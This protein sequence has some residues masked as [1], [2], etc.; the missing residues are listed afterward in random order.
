MLIAF[1]RVLAE[2]TRVLKIVD[3]LVTV[4]PELKGVL[5]L[6]NTFKNPTKLLNKEAMKLLRNLA[7]EQIKTMETY[8]NKL[9]KISTFGDSF[10]K[11]LDEAVGFDTSK[12]INIEDVKISLSSSWL[13]WGM[14]LPEYKLDKGKSASNTRFGLLFLMPKEAEHT[15]LYPDIAENV[16]KAMVLSLGHAGTVGWNMGVFN[17]NR[18][19]SVS[20]KRFT[21]RT[22]R[23]KKYTNIRKTKLDISKWM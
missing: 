10:R 4:V 2:T 21:T 1:L 20:Q 13:A 3:E 22:K 12:L 16:W 8:I 6:F 9:N 11:K 5:K 19:A 23:L 15:Y 7:P 14:W 17:R 18:S